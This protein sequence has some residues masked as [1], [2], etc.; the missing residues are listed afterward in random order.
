MSAALCRASARSALLAGVLLLAM[1]GVAGGAAAEVPWAP[2]PTAG[3]ECAHVPVP[4]DR[5]GAVA[6]TVSL[7]IARARAQSN[8]SNTAVVALAGGPGQAA[9]P[10]TADFAQVLAPAIADRDLLVFDQ[11]G[12]GSSGALAC[13]SLRSATSLLKAVSGCASELGPRRG[14]YR[15]ADSVEDVEA[16]RAA[17]GYDKLVLFGVSYGTKV[18]AAYAAAH[19][20]RVAAL[21]LD[22]V[23]LP[24]GPDPFARSTMSSVSRVLRDLCA[25]GACRRATPDVGG[26]LKRLAARLRRTSLR[27]RVGTGSGRRAPYRMGQTELFDILLAG[28]LNPTLRAELPGSMRAALEGD[29]A[30]LLRL[31]V[32]SEGLTTGAGWSRDASDA[33][34]TSESSLAGWATGTGDSDALYLATICEEVPFPWTRAA[35]A[36]RRAGEAV[37]AAN[38]I[39]RAQLGPFSPRAALQGGPIP[40]CLGWPAASAAPPAP[41]PLPAVR[42]LV[43]DGQM[44]LRTPFEDASGLASRIP[45]ASVVEVPFTGHSVLSSDD[46]GC[47]RSAMTSFFAGGTPGACPASENPYTPTPRPPAR[48]RFV[49]AV[50]RAGR[51]G[52]TVGAIGAT[53]TDARRQIIGDALALGRP[54]KHVAGLRAGRATVTGLTGFRLERYQYVPG[55]VVS[56]TVPFQGTAKLSVHGGGAAAGLLRVTASGAVSG[57][58]GGHRVSLGSSSSSAGALPSLRQALARPRLTP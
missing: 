47:A 53:V 24:E 19:P 50:G 39:P 15:T 42:T 45:G 12:T 5:S 8:P 38:R 28:D 35:S 56:G 29:S 10:L 46:S 21:V 57:S 30:P 14:S 51:I 18:A 54:P 6:G 23:V 2:C 36:T 41:G 55:V 3:Y 58:L 11:R 43:L 17:A 4:L 25:A 20:E 37:A 48:L 7:A 52:Q 16:I 49:H 22:S 40:F 9:L 27:G 1:L 31:S 44:D 32:R 33:H 26:D 13:S 34:R